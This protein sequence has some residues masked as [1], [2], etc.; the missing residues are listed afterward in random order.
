[1]LSHTFYL[2][3]RLWMQL[4]QLKISI[5]PQLHTP[6]SDML[7]PTKPLLQPTLDAFQPWILPKHVWYHIALS[8]SLTLS[9]IHVDQLLS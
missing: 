7:I 2:V 3:H 1:M 5:M 9:T 6:H 8:H 4:T